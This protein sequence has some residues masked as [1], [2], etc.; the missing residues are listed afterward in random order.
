VY[1]F[2]MTP[3]AKLELLI[4]ITAAVPCSSGAGAQAIGVTIANTA[5]LI[6]CTEA[7]RLRSV[8]MQRS[9][10]MNPRFGSVDSLGN[11]QKNPAMRGFSFF[12]RHRSV[13]VRNPNIGRL[14]CLARRPVPKL[15]DLRVDSR[16]EHSRQA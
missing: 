9:S 15:R 4:V 16:R 8:R 1:F 5:I 6:H 14:Q 12:K 7:A 3:S 10:Q 11:Q 13:R 2:G